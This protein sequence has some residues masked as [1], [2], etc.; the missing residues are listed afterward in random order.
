MLTSEGYVIG[1][2]IGA[3]GR[4]LALADLQGHIVAERSATTPPGGPDATVGELGGMAAACLAEVRVRP[5]HLLRIGCGFSGPVDAGG[6][7]LS[8]PRLAGWEQAPLA[9]LLEDRLGAPALVDNDARVAALGEARYGAGRGERNLAYVHLGTGLG[10]GLVFD[11]RLYHGA[12]ATAGEIGH[13]LIDENGPLCSCGKPGHLEAYASGTAIVRR[14]L[15]LVPRLAPDGPLAR[16]QA[17]SMTITPAQ[18]FE[19]ARDGDEAA[20]AV[21]GEAIRTLAIALANLVTT[22]NPGVIVVGGRVT[23]AGP[24]L[25]APLQALVRRFAMAVPARVVRIVPTALKSDAIVVG[26]VALA[27]QSLGWSSGPAD[28]A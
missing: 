3:R 12:T 17:A 21:T 7:V 1:I 27:I 16:A 8:S 28:S 15:E 11:G 20:R 9:S 6:V 5:D 26:A 2:E 22:T 10:G 18:V 24:L 23:E 14:A 4:R 13:L 19:A 25:F